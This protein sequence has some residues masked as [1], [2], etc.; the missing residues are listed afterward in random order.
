MPGRAW[1]E[2]IKPAWFNVIRRLQNVAKQS[3]QRVGVVS[4]RILIDQNGDPVSWTEP[5]LV[6]LEPKRQGAEVLELLAD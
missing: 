6:S 4:I 1:P 2:D 3:N 5:E